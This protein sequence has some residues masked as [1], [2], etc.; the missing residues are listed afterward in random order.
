VPE[1]V[2]ALSAVAG[3]GAEG[4]SGSA[5]V[6]SLASGLAARQM[7]ARPY[8]RVEPEAW[9]D[10]GLGD[11]LDLQLLRGTAV[12]SERLGRP[13]GRTWIADPTAGTDTLAWLRTR[14]VDQLVMPE[15]SLA[16]LDER[17][18]PVTLTQTFLIGGTPGMRAAVA[19]RGLAAHS[20]STGDA[21]LD[22]HHL[23]ADLVVLYLDQPGAS[24]G[25]VVGGADGP[26]PSAPF[27]DTALRG[28]GAIPVL[29]PVT[30]DDLFADVPTA[31]ARG[32]TDGRSTPL[33][34]AIAPEPA[35]RLGRFPEALRT[36]RDD[37]TTYEAAVGAS[38]VRSQALRNRLLVAGASPLSNTERARYTSA[39]SETV[40]TELAKVVIPE[41]QT[42]TLTARSGRVPLIVRNS[43]GYPLTVLIR[44]R[45][46]KLAFPDESDLELPLT[47]EQETNRIE[48]RVR[49]RTSGSS[50]L[51]ITLWSP[52]GRLQL[53][54]SRYTVRSTAFSGVG[55]VLSIGALAFLVAWWARSARRTLAA[56]RAGA[57][58]RHPVG[59]EPRH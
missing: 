33:Q 39:V 32:Q 18:F 2:D 50:P 28:L 12:V 49:A 3:A 48:L 10:A 37:I 34:R 41:R 40:R 20:G 31:G 8:V 47:L 36:A 24:R 30:L 52:D 57:R 19:D 26:R 25:V 7:S 4:E 6:D 9:L 11:E 44:L 43:A 5:V 15:A 42:I 21:V 17:T 38:N 23:L 1:T 16:P 14:G 53:A 59:V 51:L 13:D 45:S 27:L 46:E 22:A 54:E 35:S 29:A 55:L 56:R 58:A